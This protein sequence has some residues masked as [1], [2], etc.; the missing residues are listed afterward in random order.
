[1]QVIRATL[2]SETVLRFTRLGVDSLTSLLLLGFGLL[3]VLRGS[4]SLGALTAFYAYADQFAEGS[5]KLQELLHEVFTVR[6]ACSRYFAL[7]DR[8]P[9]MARRASGRTQ[10]TQLTT[11]TS[12]SEG[13]SMGSAAEVGLSRAALESATA[14]P[15]TC[16]G[17]LELCGVSIG[18]AGRA[19]AALRDVN[20]QIHAGET[21]AL[22]GPSGAGKSTL[23]KVLNRLYDPDAGCVRLDGRDIRSFDVQWL[24]TQFGVVAQVPALF[25]MSIAENVAFG[26][27]EATPSAEA[28]E[29]A[30]EAS[31]ASQFV[32][33]LPDGA[34]TRIGEGG[35][36]L[37]GGQR[38]RLAVARA[39]VRGP[40]VLLWDEA[41]S[42][43]DSSTERLVHAALAKHKGRRTAVVVAHRL[44]SV[45]CADRVAVL[46]DGRVVQLGTPSE[47]KEQEGWYRS[48]FFPELQEHGSA[49]V[50]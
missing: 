25:D 12:T 11:L 13:S 18:F 22:V 44:S 4:L 47:L 5:K 9:R 19:E 36:R 31:G 27:L 15:V 33:R 2:V 32:R 43:L 21:L 45:L 16:R 38:Q 3:G 35:H 29:A 30:L 39:L 34:N 6:P 7:L 48:N 42:S 37:S 46:V 1:M 23:L 50:A 49:R 28:I 20:L 14:T 41:T 10:P 8:T 26:T 40:S 24:R 17:A